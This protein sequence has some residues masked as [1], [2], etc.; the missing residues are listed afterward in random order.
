MP[1]SDVRVR[2]GL[3]NKPLKKGLKQSENAVVRFAKG[4]KTQLLGILGV[5]AFSGMVRSVL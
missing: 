2:L 5:G 3:D 4:A 1:S